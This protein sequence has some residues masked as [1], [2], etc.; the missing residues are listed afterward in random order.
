MQLCAIAIALLGISLTACAQSPPVTHIV[1][2]DA[3]QPVE[4]HAA[5]ELVDHLGR[6]L[7]SRFPVIAEGAERPDGRA[8]VVGRT[9][10]N[11]AAHDPDDW[12]HDTIH[13]GYGSGDIAIIGQGR[14]AT[15]FAAYEFLRDQ[16]CRW[17]LPISS[18][19]QVPKRE[20]LDLQRAPRRHTPSFTPQRGW[21]PIA[22]SPGV[23]NAHFF[24]WA[25]H[26]GLNTMSNTTATKCPPE[27]GH[28]YHFRRGHT[29]ITLIPSGDHTRRP[30]VFAAHPEWYPLVNGRRVFEY[31]DGRPAQ[32]CLSN[33]AV[34]EEAARHVIEYFDNH[35]DAAVFSVGH[36][37]EP[38]Y[39]CECN[40]CLAMDGPGSTWR[41]NDVYD[42]YGLRSRQGPG[43]MSDRYVT[44]VNRVA[45]LVAAKRPDRMISFYAYGSTISPPRRPDW[46]LEP[47]VVIEY[48]YGDG[49]CLRHDL[50]DAQ[51]PSNL[52]FTKWLTEWRSRGNPVVV[53]DYPTQGGH[54]NVPS[55]FVRRYGDYVAHCLRLGVS[56]WSGETQG[57][58]A[59]SGLAH[60]IKARLLWD[61]DADID[62]MVDEFCGFMYGAAAETMVRFHDTLE[63]H[64]MRLPDHAIWGSWVRDLDEEH[65]NQVD[66]ILETAATQARTPDAIKHVAMMRVAVNN[67]RLTRMA[68]NDELQADPDL[69]RKYLDLCD[70]TLSLH[71]RIDEPLPVTMSGPWEDK[72]RGSY[73]PPFEAINGRELLA[74][75]IVWRFRIDPKDEGMAGGWHDDADTSADP[76]QNIRVD[77]YW[78]DQGVKFHGVAWYATTFE[79]PASTDGRLWLLFEALDGAAEVWIDGKSAGKLP[80]DPWDKP[81]AVEVTSLLH[82][83]R[84]ANLRIRVVKK[85]YAAGIPK[86]VRLMASD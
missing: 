11:L 31:K 21:H 50:D 44:F 53:Y 7:G 39:W 47:N 74:L 6:M 84:S 28:G 81:K 9:K 34:A 12:A 2:P 72:L 40:D 82:P 70:R 41:T 79:A 67:L 69:F 55:G 26:N 29:L 86:P 36:N 49:I 83:G 80:A 45:R 46:K 71:R 63:E 35:P 43:P 68:A 22:A 64:I 73:R 23:W 56:G 52:H 66:G 15:L 17:Y 38:S 14:Q 51:C 19:T 76:W 42:A 75:P 18:A 13:I 62:A 27:L 61:A 16:G 8:L 20:R 57:T 78:T 24:P 54:A 5:N 32:A 77:A 48:A 30:E 33:P 65:I 60:Y 1:I 4:R 37:D 25:A 85:L 59:G 58:P 10:D 3:P